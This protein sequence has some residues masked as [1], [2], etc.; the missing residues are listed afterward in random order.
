MKYQLQNGWTKEAILERIREKNGF[1]PCS[2][3]NGVCYY[4]H[5]K[6]GKACFAGA[7]IPDEVYSREI[8]GSIACPIAAAHA[9]APAAKKAAT[10]KAVPKATAVKK[11]AA[12]KQVLLDHGLIKYPLDPKGMNALQCVHDQFALLGKTVSSE[13]EELTKK[14]LDEEVA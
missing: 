3:L 14:F 2:D 1:S 5:P 4:R 12:A 7:F 6:T 8:E 10:V 9:A 13:L 11:A